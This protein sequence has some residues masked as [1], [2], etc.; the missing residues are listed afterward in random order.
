VN[1]AQNAGIKWAE[2]KSEQPNCHFSKNEGDAWG[3]CA[4]TL[5]LTQAYTKTK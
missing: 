3:R 1:T 2:I 4:L 5:F